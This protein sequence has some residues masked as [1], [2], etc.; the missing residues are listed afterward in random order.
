MHKLMKPIRIVTWID[1]QGNINPVRFQVE[2]IAEERLI[3]KV[4]KVLQRNEEKIAGQRVINYRCRSIIADQLRQY[5]IC[6]E[7]PT[8]RWYLSLW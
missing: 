7:L 6:Y 4:E 3:I 2:G 8:C 1:E 5:E